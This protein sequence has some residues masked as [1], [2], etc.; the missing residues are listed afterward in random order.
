MPQPKLQLLSK[1]VL[2]AVV[3]EVEGAFSDEG[4]ADND[5]RVFAGDVPD[6]ALDPWALIEVV[7]NAPSG[8]EDKDSPVE[9]VFMGVSL[10][11]TEDGAT[12]PYV[13]ALDLSKATTQ[14]ITDST[15]SVSGQSV[16]NARLTL[17]E[18]ASQTG[19]EQVNLFGFTLQFEFHLE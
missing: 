11:A 1:E 8:R 5:R 13:A 9:V 18:P 7:D 19:P 10:F 2:K 12:N 6:T 14:R 17:S 15:F 3:S 4:Y 16:Y